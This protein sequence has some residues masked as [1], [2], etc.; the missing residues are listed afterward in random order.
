[1]LV[2][3]NRL[4][5]NYKQISRFTAFFLT[6][7]NL[8]PC[9]LFSSSFRLPFFAC[10][11]IFFLSFSFLSFRPAGRINEIDV[12]QNKSSVMWSFIFVFLSL[13]FM[14]FLLR[15][16]I[17]SAKSNSFTDNFQENYRDYNQQTPSII[18]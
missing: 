14:L 11:L 15:I 8:F 3:K 6:F 5:G 4:T 2:I 13:L 16:T 18:I 10:S 7:P 9:C 12:N 17:N 1:M